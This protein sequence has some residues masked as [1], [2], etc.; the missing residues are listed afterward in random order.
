MFQRAGQL[1]LRTRLGLSLIIA[2]IVTIYC[3]TASAR[4]IPSAVA[5][6]VAAAESYG[7]EGNVQQLR[8]D[9]TTTMWGNCAKIFVACV[10][11][12]YL[13][14]GLFGGTGG[15]G[16]GGGGGFGFST[17]RT[18]RMDGGSGNG[19]SGAPGGGGGGDPLSYALA[20]ADP[21]PPDF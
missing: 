16:G 18:R 5:A 4:D 20:N 17:T 14:S 2:A 8:R 13:V 10:V 1:S 7:Y 21:C 9:A 11:V 3:Y 15:G 6:G 19:G 12:V